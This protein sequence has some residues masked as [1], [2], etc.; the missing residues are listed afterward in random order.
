MCRLL[1]LFISIG[2]LGAD[3]ASASAV[4]PCREPVERARQIGDEK[5]IESCAAARAVA[6]P[7]SVRRCREWLA[8]CRKN[9]QHPLP[10]GINSL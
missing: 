2:L 10:P 6:T 9:P 3:Q 1:M 4:R 8:A 7:A 5:W